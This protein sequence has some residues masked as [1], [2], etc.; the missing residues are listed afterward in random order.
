MIELIVIFVIIDVLSVTAVSTFRVS[1]AK[2]RQKE[3]ALILSAYIKASQMYI[4]EHGLMPVMSIDIGLYMS[5]TG[6]SSPS[7]RICPQGAPTNFSLHSRRVCYTHS[8]IFQ[9]W[10]LSYPNN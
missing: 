3:A 2:A 7:L 4:A 10:M 9:I 8:G 1:A 5:V 6:C